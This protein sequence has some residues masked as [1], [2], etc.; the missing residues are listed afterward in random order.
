M[1]YEVDEQD[2]VRTAPYASGVEYESD[3]RRVAFEADAN[4]LQPS[5]TLTSTNHLL[6]VQVGVQKQ[7]SRSG[8]VKK[9]VMHNSR[10]VTQ[11]YSRLKLTSGRMEYRGS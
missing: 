11:N 3:H 1:R 6:I 10:W 7:T 5:I 2:L 8:R 9:R 4:I